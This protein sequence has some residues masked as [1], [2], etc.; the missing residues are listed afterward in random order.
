MKMK[1]LNWFVL[2]GILL[3]TASCGNNKQN[4]NNSMSDTMVNTDSVVACDSTSSDTCLSGGEA[5]VSDSTPAPAAEETKVSKN[6]KQIDKLLKECMDDIE[7]I[8]MEG[9]ENGKPL[10]PAEL[11]FSEVREERQEL[12]TD[13]QKLKS[14]QS[15]MSEQQK[16]KFDDI[17]KKANKIFKD[18]AF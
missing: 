11:Q 12:F 14:M 10:D 13:I 2:A 15:E 18:L 1:K 5:A 8:M 17:Q 9:Y 16:S 4:E 7:D 3:A 6:S